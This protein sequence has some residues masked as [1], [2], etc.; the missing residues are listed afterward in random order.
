MLMIVPRRRARGPGHQSEHCHPEADSHSVS[1][2]PMDPCVATAAIGRH[3]PPVPRGQCSSYGSG[4]I[5][6]AQ[7]ADCVCD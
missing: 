4:A 1:E 3:A 2:A 7:G 6:A 5:S